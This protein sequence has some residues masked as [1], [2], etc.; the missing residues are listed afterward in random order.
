MKLPR[1]SVLQA[2][3]LVLCISVVSYSPKL[4]AQS[5][6]GTPAAQPAATIPQWQI[7]AGGKMAFD[8]A[9]VKR[10]MAGPSAFSGNVLFSADD[11]FTPT[12]GLYSEANSPLI[13][14]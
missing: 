10:N 12:G 9:S 2:L 11:L 14:Y 13:S 6:G 3:L 1:P 7:A 5:A 8:V 4:Q